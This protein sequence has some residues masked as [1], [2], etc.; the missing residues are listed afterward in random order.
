MFSALGEAMGLS[1]IAER[2]WVGGFGKVEW[3][4]IVARQVE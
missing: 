4:W 2:L 3:G 1:A